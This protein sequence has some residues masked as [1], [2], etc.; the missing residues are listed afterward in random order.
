LD[1]PT[2]TN[3][4]Q[5]IPV[6]IS[7]FQ[8]YAG[9]TSLAQDYSSTTKSLAQ[10][11]STVV[12]SITRGQLTTAESSSS[13][14]ANIENLLNRH[15][16]NTDILPSQDYPVNIGNAPNGTSCLACDALQSSPPS[17]TNRGGTKRK[18]SR[19]PRRSDEDL[20]Q[21]T[22][23][24]LREGID[25]LS[26]ESSPGFVDPSGEDFPYG[27]ANACALYLWNWAESVE[28]SAATIVWPMRY[29]AACLLL[30]GSAFTSSLTPEIDLHRTTLHNWRVFAEIVNSIINEMLLSWNVKAYLLYNIFAGTQPIT[31]SMGHTIADINIAKGSMLN[32]IARTSK[33]RREAFISGVVAALK[34]HPP[35]S[36]IE[37]VSLFNPTIILG[38]LL[39]Q[40]EYGLPTI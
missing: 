1:H 4:E 23:A 21:D 15:S 26:T 29:I 17:K 39:P 36:N 27:D 9:S 13:H 34:T 28:N 10:G 38:R 32:Q 8:A 2:N 18:R 12:L 11:P 16:T 40:R 19:L 20:V 33:S 14:S 25:K 6:A 37:T 30:V 7:R 31:H 22:A 5:C 3:L 24:W 35:D